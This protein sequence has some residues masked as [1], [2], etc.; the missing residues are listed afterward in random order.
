[1][2]YNVSRIYD[3]LRSLPEITVVRQSNSFLSF[4]CTICNY[5]AIAK[6]GN[7]QGASA[8]PRISA[9]IGWWNGTGAKQGAN[10]F[11]N[12]FAFQNLYPSEY[13]SETGRHP[14]PPAGE[15]A[16]F[17]KR[18]LTLFCLPTIALPINSNSFLKEPERSRPVSP[19]KKCRP[20]PR[21]NMR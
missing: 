4:Y 18:L 5:K 13:L 12:C 8:T 10:L 20:A 11:S 19:L 6:C 1:M 2:S 9:V 21:D 3:I 17:L 14:L 7:A 16:Q 15:G